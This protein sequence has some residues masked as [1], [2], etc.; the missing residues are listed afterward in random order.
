MVLG[1]QVDHF[2]DIGIHTFLN[3]KFTASSRI[4]RWA[5][6]FEGS[7]IAHSEKGADIISD[8]IALGAVQVPAD[9]NPIVFMSDRPT[10]GGYSK[11]AT[12]ISVDISKIAQMKTGDQVQFKKIDIE[13]ARKIFKDREQFF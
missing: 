5:Y 6:R 7:V 13:E 2:T 8:G 9:G 4:D 10:T 3:S 11:I 12:V 1:P